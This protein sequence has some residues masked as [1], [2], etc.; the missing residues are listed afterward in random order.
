MKITDGRNEDYERK[1]KLGRRWRLQ[2]EENEDYKQK[3]KLVRVW[4]L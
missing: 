1:K 4:R 2:M 3:K